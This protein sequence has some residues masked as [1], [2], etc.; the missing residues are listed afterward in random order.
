[1]QPTTL[2]ES[3]LET[4]HRPCDVQKSALESIPDTPRP[5]QIRQ[6]P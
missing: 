2:T 4:I 1:M 6:T 5:M 3:I